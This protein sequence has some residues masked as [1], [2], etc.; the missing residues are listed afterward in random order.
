MTI[1]INAL[2]TI[3]TN[4]GGRIMDE[5]EIDKNV[6]NIKAIWGIENMEIKPGE[7]KIMRDYLAG[8]ISADDYIGELK[9]ED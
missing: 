5:K 6:S 4:V 2:M 1:C 8:K 7:E 9:E 3:Y